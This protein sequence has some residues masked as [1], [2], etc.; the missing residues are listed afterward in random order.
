MKKKR[1]KRVNNRVKSRQVRD[2]DKKSHAVRV[3]LNKLKMFLKNNKP[4]DEGEENEETSS[5]EDTTQTNAE[6]EQCEAG[7]NVGRGD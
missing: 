3:Y 7:N 4:K 5:R 6:C 1:L 2:G